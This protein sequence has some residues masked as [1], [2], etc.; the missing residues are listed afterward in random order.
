M[1]KAMGGIV[2]AGMPGMME[3]RG[4][5]LTCSHPIANS[6]AAI[7]T[8]PKHKTFLAREPLLPGSLYTL[9][10]RALNKARHLMDQ[11]PAG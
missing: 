5:R 9:R 10:R 1:M 8:S 4:Y 7:Q 3:P 11:T 2:V 6:V